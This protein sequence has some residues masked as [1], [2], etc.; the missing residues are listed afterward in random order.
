MCGFVTC[1]FASAD[2]GPPRDPPREFA[3]IPAKQPIPRARRDATHARSNRPLL[4]HLHRPCERLV[5]GEHRME[6]PVEAAP[7][8]GIE[9]PLRFL[10]QAI[11]GGVHVKRE[12]LAPW[13][14]LRA[15][16]ES[17]RAR[18]RP[19]RQTNPRRVLVARPDSL[20]LRGLV[21]A[22]DVHRDA[23]FLELV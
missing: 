5:L 7:L 14:T 12:I 21:L 10:D 11:G 8:H 20:E 6:A 18:L 22:R 2:C 13:R 4:L 3:R 1:C 16:E 15:M 19:K 23:D 17:I 9:F